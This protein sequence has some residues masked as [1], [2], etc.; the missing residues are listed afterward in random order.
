MKTCGAKTRAGHP[1]KRPAGAGTD[2]LGAGRCKL[3]GGATP[4]KHGNTI[5]DPEVKRLRQLPFIEE[6]RKLT[7]EDDILAVR[8]CQLIYIQRK[9]EKEGTK[10]EFSAEEMK[11]LTDFAEKANRMDY[12]R[13]KLLQE[14]RAIIGIEEV[15]RLMSNFL[16]AVLAAGII[17]PGYEERLV[18]IAVDYRLHQPEATHAN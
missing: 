17:K 15:V 4:I 18:Q 14:H 6:A 7:M 8:A 12:R 1:C 3:H 13:K 9:M 5:Q 2:H 16:E 11:V 10:A